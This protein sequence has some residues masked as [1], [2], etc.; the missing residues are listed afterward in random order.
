MLANRSEPA[1]QGRHRKHQGARKAGH[2]RMSP[3]VGGLRRSEEKNALQGKPEPRLD[4]LHLFFEPG[5]PF[6]G[7]V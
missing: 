3:V 2:T 1:S 7:L 4:D 5:Y 6:R